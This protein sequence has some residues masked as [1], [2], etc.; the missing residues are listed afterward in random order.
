MATIRFEGE[1]REI[2]DGAR[3]YETCE[4]LGMPFGCTEGECGT[5]TCTV[6]EGMENL[7]PLNDKELDMGLDEGQ[8]LACQ[9]IIKSGTVEFSVE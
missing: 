2:P 4:E 7:E 3:C 9:C 1:E 5:C 8:R 6:V